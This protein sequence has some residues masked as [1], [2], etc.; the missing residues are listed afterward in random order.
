METVM[1]ERTR[2]CSGDA[3]V[4]AAVALGWQV[5]T[6]YHS[7]PPRGPVGDPVRGDRLPGRSGVTPATQSKWL[8]E[9]TAAGAAG[10]PPLPPP[11][12]IPALAGPAVPLRSWDP[13]HRAHPSTRLP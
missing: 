1:G 6:L 13:P 3:R 11:L 7:P 4:C 2:P 9:Q 12:P 8:G 10:L 5:T